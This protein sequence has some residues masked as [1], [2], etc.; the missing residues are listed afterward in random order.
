L[1]RNA[2][3]DD[4][5]VI[6]ELINW[7]AERGRMLF[8]SLADL[9]ESLRDF[10]IYQLDQEIVGCCSLPI[11]WADL[12]EVKSLAVK[13]DFQRKGI[14]SALVQAAIQEARQLHVGKIF[15]LTMETD[16]FQKLGFKKVPVEQLPLKV[17]SDCVHCPKQDCCDEIAMMLVLNENK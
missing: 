3:L 11:V 5:P 17:W 15:T 1:I 9:Y 14:G 8:R 13:E 12:A 2:R 16:F 4:V 7:H 6:H 10:T